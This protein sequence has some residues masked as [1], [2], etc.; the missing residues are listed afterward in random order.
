M[1][2]KPDILEKK[3]ISTISAPTIKI[4]KGLISDDN[5]KSVIIPPTIKI[6][7][8]LKTNWN[9][10]E[11]WTCIHCETNNKEKDVECLVCEEKK[12]IVKKVIKPSAPKKEISKTPTDTTAE[13]ERKEKE[14]REKS[15]RKKKKSDK[16]FS[17]TEKNP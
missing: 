17:S 12:S 9:I 10:V 15:S 3:P 11:T 4:G 2:K 6:G 1:I 5:N 14:K 16:W 7:K 13:K 8:G